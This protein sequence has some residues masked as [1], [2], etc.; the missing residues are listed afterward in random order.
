MPVSRPSAQ[1]P[2][3]GHDGHTLRE[4]SRLKRLRIEN[5]MIANAV[6]LEISLIITCRG[7]GLIFEFELPDRDAIFLSGMLDAE[8]EPLAIGQ[9]AKCF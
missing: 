2:G 3:L 4:T 1:H 8:H 9:A 7:N 6:F 5:V